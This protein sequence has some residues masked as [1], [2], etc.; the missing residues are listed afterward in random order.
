MK[1]III[2]AVM[3]LATAGSALA[4]GTTQ[5]NV[6]ATVVG[7][8][9]FSAAGTSLSFGTLP[10]DASGNALGATATASPTFWCT[11]NASYSITDDSGLNKL[12][13]GNPRLKS[14]T[15]GTPEY[16]AYTLAYTPATG[17]GNGPGTPIIL[18]VTGTIGTTYGS[19]SP[20][21]YND[22]VTL[23]ITP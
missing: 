2:T 10:F 23:S 11:R 16:I 8:C 22:T 18:N 12:S 13:P 7:T 3:V 17:A 14:A 6:S 15:L 21:T 20:D 1:K 9:K 5:L 4:S 19:N